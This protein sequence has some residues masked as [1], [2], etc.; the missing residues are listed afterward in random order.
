[1]W[2]LPESGMVHLL[3]T[4]MKKSVV[5]GV[6]KPTYFFAI[7]LIGI[8]YSLFLTQM[9]TPLSIFF[10]AFIWMIFLF[11]I[12]NKVQYLY[13]FPLAVSINH[14]WVDLDLGEEDA[15]VQIWTEEK[16]WFFAPESTI[17]IIVEPLSRISVIVADDGGNTTLGHLPPVAK[18]HETDFLNW[19]NH[20]I[21][22]GQIY[23][24]GSKDDLFSTARKREEQESGLLEREW[25][26]VTPGALDESAEISARKS[27]LISATKKEK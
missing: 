5:S 20:A 19:V 15:R 17:K 2:T 14:P 22:V 13:Q 3:R 11:W 18:R 4:D 7:L 9:L 8:N 24:G 23:N 21:L 16:G 10:L 27:E 25:G 26:D 1:M 12:K 6:I